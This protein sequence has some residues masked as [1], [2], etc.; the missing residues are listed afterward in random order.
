M[1]INIVICPL[2]CLYVTSILWPCLAPLS[3]PFKSLPPLSKFTVCVR[4]CV[5]RRAC[6]RVNAHPGSA[7]DTVGIS[8]SRWFF[9]IVLAH[10]DVVTSRKC[11]PAVR[12]SSLWCGVCKLSMQEP[13]S[14]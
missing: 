14:G 7:R 12:T 6:A 5:M 3:L 13:V 4:A 11:A 10:S 1:L 9:S 8:E 2:F